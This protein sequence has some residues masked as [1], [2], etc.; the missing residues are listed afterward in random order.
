MSRKRAAAAGG[1]GRRGAALFDLSDH[2]RGGWRLVLP[3]S[4]R[5]WAAVAADRHHRDR[6]CALVLHN[7]VPDDVRRLGA[8]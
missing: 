1:D 4:L 3:R 2:G 5:D 6:I 8:A 7:N